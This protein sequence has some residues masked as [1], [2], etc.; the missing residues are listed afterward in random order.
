[1]TAAPLSLLSEDKQQ[2]ANRLAEGLDAPSLHWL[3][4]YL[5][6]L[7]AL[8]PI[9]KAAGNESAPRKAV[10]A[11]AR[12]TVLYGSQTGNAKRVAEQLA[13]R[14]TAAGL[15]VRLLR[16]DAYPLQELKKERLLY[17]VVSTHSTG[18]E[19]EPPDDSRGFFEH[20]ESRRAPRLPELSYAVLA[21][22]DTSYPDFCGIGRR[23][24]ERLSALGAT[25]LFAR[26][27]A[28][29]DI[30]TV[31][32]PWAD[33]ALEQ[34]RTLLKLAPGQPSP[35][36]TSGVVTPLH[37]ARQAWSRQHPFHAEVLANQR[38][39][40]SDSGKDV[41]HIELSLEGSGLTYQ[42]GDALGVWPTQSPT[43]VDAVLATLGL[44][45]NREVDFND[46]RLPLQQWLG[47]RR[48]L[49]GLTRPFLI[50]HAERGDHAALKALL[51]PDAR[52]ELG[53]LLDGTPLLDLLRRYPTAWDADALVAALRP[54]APR[55]YSI[56]SSLKQVENEVHLTVDRL[57]YRSDGEERWG[58]ASHHLSALDEGDTVPV[59][60][61]ANDRFR[62]PAEPSRDI[63]MIGPGTGVAPFRAFVQE[64]AAAGASGR[65][66]L[67]FGNPYRRTDFLYQLEWQQAL[68]NGT[69]SRLDVAFS[70]DQADKVYV[71]DRLREQGREL[72]AW[73]QQG[74]HLYVCGDA[75]RMAP[76]VHAT[77]LDIAVAHGGKS[78]EDAET[79]LRSLLDEGRY[80][81]DVY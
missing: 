51:Q 52:A 25:S 73:L 60:I 43:L 23:L 58:V 29:V 56:A 26:G 64:R 70:R 3:S 37:P 11:Q 15:E 35:A 78:H 14:A 69:L 54:L 66:W 50:A 38:I 77:L 9:G 28:D 57:H 81:R 61:E 30:E 12:L 27:E 5:A 40:A 79:W 32:A 45:G 47:Q 67:F 44:D 21:L 18:N 76:D 2:L 16:A 46:E 41:R 10:D 49:T 6:G 65:N 17:A 59:F 36:P 31:A 20:L 62:L 75:N 19:V 7:A 74:A 13:E 68:R 39:V 63:I 71:Q 80:V 4:G 48:E 53:A 22:G 24:D 33:N 1:M 55:M 72:W 8:R 42:P 34:A